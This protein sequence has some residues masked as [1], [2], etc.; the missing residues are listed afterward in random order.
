VERITEVTLAGNWTGPAVDAVELDY[1]GRHRRRLALTCESGRL[2]MLDLPSAVQMRDGDALR[3]ADGSWVAVRAAHESL[4]EL[5]ATGAHA[6]ARLA[7]HFGNRHVPAQLGD[8]WLRIRP[9]HVL[10]ELARR[11]GAE[12]IEVEAPFEPEP[13]AYAQHGHAMV[14]RS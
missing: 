2:L 5:R 7:W 8:G 12:V 6:V 10:A 11:L 13:G 4:V 1:D 9:D 3:L 14:R